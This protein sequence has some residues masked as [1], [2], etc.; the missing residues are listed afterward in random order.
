MAHVGQDGHI[1]STVDSYV[2]VIPVPA[3]V[4]VVLNKKRVLQNQRHRFLLPGVAPVRPRS[5]RG[6]LQG[7]ETH[8]SLNTLYWR[9]REGRE[10]IPLRD[11]ATL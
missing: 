10:M 11:F 3:D 6:R 9:R 8:S 7:V 4:L 1:Q 2:P 5:C